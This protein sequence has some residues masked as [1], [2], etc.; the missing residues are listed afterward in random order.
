MTDLRMTEPDVSRFFHPVLAA[1]KLGRRPV[2]LEVAGRRFTLAKNALGRAEIADDR[3]LQVLEKYRYLWVAAKG[4]PASFAP[5][6]SFETE[7]FEQVGEFG[8]P[9]KAPLHVALDNFCEDEH[10]PWVH[11]F[12][13][14]KES[15]LAGLEFESE[16]FDDRTEVY[17]RAPQRPSLWTPALLIKKGD[18]FHNQW[19]TRFDPVRTVYTLHWRDPKTSARRPVMSRFAIYFVP[20][21]AKTTWLHVFAFAK[22]LDPRLRFLMPVIRRL[23]PFIGWNEVNDDARFIP[24]VADTPFEMKGMR[25][26]KFD[27]PLLHNHKLLQAIYRSEPRNEARNDR[28]S[29]DL[30]SD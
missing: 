23:V 4:T 3:S 13:G 29:P 6:L 30:D 15:Q 27:K 8:M 22:V 10:T 16:N 12:L 7:G 1:K 14:W 2:P 11:S 5:D 25:L 28:K 20:E 21:T 24:N 26:G 18:I 17:Y 9:F 19:V